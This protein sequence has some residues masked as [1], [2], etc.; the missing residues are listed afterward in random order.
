MLS[1]AE[2]LFLLELIRDKYGTGYSPHVVAVISLAKLQARLSIL[3][4]VASKREGR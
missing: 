3:L 4:E 2:I 1:K